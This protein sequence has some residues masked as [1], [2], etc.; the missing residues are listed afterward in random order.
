ML[1]SDC[2]VTVSGLPIAYDALAR[3]AHLPDQL[4]ALLCSRCGTVLPSPDFDDGMLAKLT[5]LSRFGLG[6]DDRPLLN[7]G[8]QAY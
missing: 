7:P 2:E 3:S 1:C 4:T 6:A 8:K 5:Q